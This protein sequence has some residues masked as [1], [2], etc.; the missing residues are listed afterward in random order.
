MTGMF[1]EININEHSSTYYTLFSL[2]PHE[3]GPVYYPT[4]AT[5]TLGSHAVLDF[6]PHPDPSLA[7]TLQLG[8]QPQPVFSIYLAPRSLFVQCDEL[9]KTYL[10]G[11]AELKEDDFGDAE[12]WGR[13][14]NKWAVELGEGDHSNEGSQGTKG[15]GRVRRRETRVSLTYRRVERVLKAKIFGSRIVK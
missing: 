13:L 7:S 11:I 14:I 9:Y 6:Y 2:Q 5:I 12:L 10:H 8:S 15:G 4:V 3:D 1:Q